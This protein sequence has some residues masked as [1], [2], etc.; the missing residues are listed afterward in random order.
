LQCA[1][2]GGVLKTRSLKS[3]GKAK[4]QGPNFTGAGEGTKGSQSQTL[5]QKGW[6]EGNLWRAKTWKSEL[7]VAG[8]L[9]SKHS[10]KEKG[11]EIEG[12]RQMLKDIQGG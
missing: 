10:D 9:V 7:A 2:K 4:G 8:S 12:A 6:E 11:Q 3:L 5:V 1:K